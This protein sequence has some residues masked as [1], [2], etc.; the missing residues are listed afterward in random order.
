MNTTVALAGKAQLSFQDNDE[1]GRTLLIT[2]NTPDPKPLVRHLV[3]IGLQARAIGHVL[4]VTGTIRRRDG[5]SYSDFGDSC[6]HLT[7]SEATTHA[8]YRIGS[9]FR[10][11]G[12]QP[13]V[14]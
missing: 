3:S 6:T 5:G 1:G 13:E 14:V 12:I 9:V 4:I 7:L 11:H 2:G 8:I 10:E